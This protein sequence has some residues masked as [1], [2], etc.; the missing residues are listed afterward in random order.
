MLFRMKTVSVRE[1]AFQRRE[2]DFSSFPSHSAL[3]S[4]GSST[5]LLS[6][7]LNITFV[8]T[9]THGNGAHHSSCHAD[10]SAV[11]C[12]V[13]LCYYSGWFGIKLSLILTVKNIVYAFG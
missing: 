3:T 11:D 13:Q 5:V 9:I 1:N 12:L 8:Y 4:H 7:S 10:C 6:R 2:V